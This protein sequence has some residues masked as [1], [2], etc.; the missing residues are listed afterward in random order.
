MRLRNSP[1]TPKKRS[2][3]PMIDIV[4]VG[5]RY[6]VRKLLGTGGSGELNSDSSLT[7]FLSSLGSV[8]LGKDIMT[9]AEVALKIGHPSSL[10]SRLRHEYNMYT[11]IAGSRGIPEVHWYGKE[12]VHKVIVLDHLRTSLGDLIDQLKFDRRETFSNASQMVCLLFK[13]NKQSY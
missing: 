9:G 11:S 3:T 6:R 10:P 1:E 2:S 4:R 8:Y 7:L 13:T 5:G 12:G